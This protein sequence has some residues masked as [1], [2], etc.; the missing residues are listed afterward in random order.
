MSH[1]SS[2]IQD[3]MKFYEMKWINGNHI[4]IDSSEFE[5]EFESYLKMFFVIKA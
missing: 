1:L 2:N 4:L 5:I 3:K